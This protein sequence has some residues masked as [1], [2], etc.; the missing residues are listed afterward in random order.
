METKNQLLSWLRVPIGG[1]MPDGY[2]ISNAY[3]RNSRIANPTERSA[4]RTLCSCLVALLILFAVQGV[5]AGNGY[6]PTINT[7]SDSNVSITENG[8]N[9]AFNIV[10]WD[11]N[12]NN[13]YWDENACIKVNGETLCTFKDLLKGYF[14]IGKPYND[15]KGSYTEVAHDTAFYKKYTG[16]LIVTRQYTVGNTVVY[17]SASN[18]RKRA[19][20]DYSMELTIDI[21]FER[22]WVDFKRTIKWEGRWHYR[23]HK[24]YHDYD[25]VLYNCNAPSVSMPSITKDNFTRTGNKKVKFTYPSYTSYSGWTTQTIMYKADC[26]NS[27]LNPSTQ[28]YGTLSQTG[29]FNVSSNYDPVTIYPRFEYYKNANYWGSGSTGNYVFRFDKNYG[30]DGSIVIPGQPRPKNLTVTSTNTYNKHVTISWERDAY[31]SSTATN[32]NWIVIRRGSDGT[33]TNL[34]IG[35]NALSNDIY[36]YTD[37]SGNLNYGTTYTYVVCYKPNNWSVSSES[38]AEG[39][40]QTVNCTLNRDFAFSGETAKAENGKIT[41]SWSHNAIQDASATNKYD[42]V[43]QQSIDDGQTWS[44]VKTISIT[45]T[46]TTGG[47]YTLDNPNGY[48]PYYFRAKITVQDIV[49][50]SAVKSATS[51]QGS[52]LS[53]FTAS[54]GTYNTLVKVAWSVN[55]KGTNTTF[56]TLQR[57]PMGNTSESS[58]ATIYSTSGTANN[59]SY[60]DETAQPGSFNE[61]R[62]KIFDT[63]NGKLYEGTPL[64]TDGFCLAQGVM[65]GRITYGSGTAVEGARVTLN[66]TNADGQAIKS[67]RSLYFDGSVNAST[68]GSGLTCETDATDINNLFGKDFTI[69]MWLKPDAT[70]MTVNDTDYELFDLPSTFGLFIR[71][72]STGYWLRYMVSNNSDMFNKSIDT[73]KWTHLTVTYSQSAKKLTLYTTQDCINIKDKVEKTS[74]TISA[75]KLKA[76]TSFGFGNWSNLGCSTPYAGYMDEVRIFNRCLS[77]AEILKNCNHTLNGSEEGLQAYYPFDEG[78]AKQIKA[79]DFSRQN[80]VSNEHHMRAGTAARCEQNIVPSEEQLSLMTYTDTNGNYTVRGIPFSGDGTNY[81]ITPSLGIHKFA[82]SNQSRFVSINSLNFSTIDFEDTSSFPVSGTVYY[83]GT[84][85][86]VDSVQFFVDGAICARDG[87]P[88]MTGVDGKYT[89]DVPIG[90]HYIT[91]SRLHHTFADGGRYPADKNNTGLRETF[92]NKMEGIDFYDNTMTVLA[93]R[94]V[95]GAIESNKQLGFGLSKNNI[96]QARITLQTTD[97][98]YHINVTTTKVGTTTN[99]NYA[100]DTLALKSPTEKVHSRAWR[101]ATSAGDATAARQIVIETDPATGE[102]AVLLPPLRYEVVNVEFV[103]TNPDVHFDYSSTKDEVNVSRLGLETTDTLTTDKR[104]TFTYL[105]R[106]DKIYNAPIDFKVTQEGCPDGAFGLESVTYKD[107]VLEEHTVGNLYTIGANGNVSYAY[108][109]PIFQQG[110]QY[111]FN[112]HACQTYKNYDGGTTN[113]VVDTVPMDSMEVTASNGLSDEQYVAIRD[114][115]SYNGK[116]YKAGDLVEMQTSTF[117]LDAQGKATYAWTAG[118][119]DLTSPYN[120]KGFYF[121]YNNGEQWPA[122]K[123]A[124][125]GIILGCVPTG[126]NFTTAAPDVVEMVLRDPPGTNS[127]ATWEAGTTVTTTHTDFAKTVTDDKLI[128][129]VQAGFW[130]ETEAGV[131]VVV[132]TRI[133]AKADADAG[134]HSQTE[135]GDEHT[136]ITTTTLDR[137]ISTSDK[138][139]FVGAQGDVFIGRAKNYLFGAARTIG[140]KEE[141]TDN[142]VLDLD[143]GITRGVEYGTYFNYAQ[144]YIE[145]TLLPNLEG[146]RD[147]LLIYH[148]NPQSVAPVPGKII[149]VTN[150]KPGDYGY[151]SSNDDEKVWGKRAARYD[152]QTGPSYTMIIPRDAQGNATVEGVDSIKLYNNNIKGWH[153]TL[154]ANE[155]AKV[156]AKSN[157]NTYLDQNISFDSGSIITQ[158]MTQTYAEGTTTTEEF[159][160]T[161]ILNAS[162]GAL[163]CETGLIVNTENEWGKHKG[164]SDGTENENHSTVSYS[165]VEDG[166]DDA[167]SVDVFKSVD[168]FSPIFITRAGQTCCPYEGARYTKYYKPGYKLD[169]ATMQIEQPHILIDN[170]KNAVKSGVANGST[171]RFDVLLTN[172]SEIGEDVFFDVFVPSTGNANAANVGLNGEPVSV[173]KVSLLVPAGEAVKAVL[174][175]DQIDPSIQDYDSIAVVIASQCQQDPASTWEVIADTAYVS[176]HYVATSSPVTMQIASTTVNTSNTDETAVIKVGGYDLGFN[177]FKGVKLQYKYANDAAWTTFK[178]YHASD[179]YATPTSEQLPEGG[180]TYYYDMK[181]KS[182]GRYTFRAMS[183]ST[184]KSEDYNVFSDEIVVIKDMQ[185]PQLLGLANPSDG[186][187]S[188]GEEISVNFNEDIRSGAI[189]EL[190]SFEVIGELNEAQIDHNVGLKMEGSDRTAYTQAD[191]TLAGRS[192]SVESW[193]N[194]AGNGTL[195]AHGRGSNTFALGADNDGHLVAT[196]GRHTYTSVKTM[197]LNKWAYLMVS[198]NYEEGDSKLSAN[199]ATDDQTIGLF[200][201]ESV[202]DYTGNGNI[203]LGRQMTGAVQELTLWDSAHTL[204]EALEYMHITKKPTEP[205]LIGYWKFDEGNGTVANDVARNRNMT[206]TSAN[207]YL[208]NKNKA[209]TLDGSNAL[210]MDITA[211]S[212]GDND[213][214]AFEMWFKGSDTNKGATLFATSVTDGPKMAFDADGMLTLSSKGSTTQLSKKNYLDN[215][216]HHVALNVLRGGTASIYVDGTIAKQVSAKAVAALQGYALFIGANKQDD[217]FENYFTGSIDEVRLWHATLNGKTIQ[218]RIHNRLQGNENGLVAYYPFEAKTLDSGNQVIVVNSPLDNALDANGRPSTVNMASTAA[219]IAYSDEAPALKPAKNATNLDFSYVASERKIV[220]TLNNTP[221]MLEGTTVQFTVKNVAD[222]NG[223]YCL[224]I[225]WTAYIR[226]NQLLW[227]TDNASVKGEQGSDM[228]FTAQ[229]EN[230]SGQ[231]ATW[232]L[233]G[234]PS[235]LTASEMAGT[236]AAT[237]QKTLTFTVDPS[238]AIGKYES[239]I[240]LYGDNQIYEPFTVSLNVT[241]ETPN[242]V[243]TLGQSTMTVVGVLNINGQM[244]E[245]TEDMV[246]AFRGTECVGVAQPKYFSSYDSYMVMLNIYGENKADLTYKAYDAST[247]TIY[248][249]VEV[250]NAN[251]N[252]FVADKTVGSFDNPVTFTPLNE[253]EQDLSLNRAGWKWFSLYAM[254]KD[255]DPEVVFKDALDAISIVTDGN[256]VSINWIGLLELDNPA[257][258]YKLKTEMP[259]VETIVGT[260]TNCTDIDITLNSGWS[261]IGYPCQASNSLGAAFAAANPQEGDQVK[262]QTSFSIYTNNEWIGTLTAMVPGEGYLY[263]STASAAKTFKYPKPEV[264][265]KKNA[266]AHKT[267]ESHEPYEA[268]ESFEDNMTMIA[269]VMNGDELVENAEVSVYAGTELRGQSTEVVKD[270]KHFLTIGGKS[271][272]DDVLTFVVT[273]GESTYYLNQTELFH[274]NAMMGSMA[275][276]YVLQLGGTTGVNAIEYA[277]VDNYYDLQGRKVENAH[278]RKGVYINQ[279]KKVVVKK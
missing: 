250:S 160:T 272:E 111:T 52:T 134:V 139:E 51:S 271:G 123:T 24:N 142:Y 208:N 133:E 240:Y 80:G 226:Q 78:M 217:T 179:T 149:F 70:K 64:E 98:R 91:A 270:G 152:A 228:S 43:V 119:P 215:A 206:L 166:D 45:S 175:V 18:P 11:Y 75:D 68:G 199:I 48:Q 243:A 69:Q 248:P 127:S 162:V 124:Q 156:R 95:G 74:I 65:S 257:T 279:S 168:A 15:S 21:A 106:F 255:S 247:G 234:L 260:P 219:D 237:K 73:D 77:Q 192:F 163:F 205:G 72:S 262:N 212:S 14:T 223:N 79:Y 115:A 145:N 180:L 220:F 13:Y 109:A 55:Q 209:V 37:M 213:D 112:I 99:R 263:N 239:T 216:W 264:S 8:L 241:G 253:I 200:G 221:D 254:P 28:A 107:A 204:A 121:T 266:P 196:I 186:I 5:R 36:S 81:I 16:K 159:T 198:Y 155:E 141:S 93:G 202:A 249:S 193:V 244:S 265:G 132:V 102:Y 94:V 269:V 86:P 184:F 201:G 144:N 22:Y 176:V 17:V 164:N 259:Y 105:S 171:A 101:N 129:H 88:V 33:Q 49:V 245:D 19:N 203:T 116:T 236:V 227:L 32:G 61:Y 53:S 38:D 10:Y 118:F 4:G 25:V 194:I 31:D 56:F 128:T 103:K 224:P 181:G 197:P 59:Y 120:H 7:T 97:E 85:I 211:I 130:Q 169:E 158:S 6:N 267:H 225:V 238:T 229:F 165:L 273:T 246:A 277:P 89:I 96:G 143:M 157:R 110:E 62:L 214:Y 147:G 92:M 195:F 256:A 60:D 178:E 207:W 131:G 232:A 173:K 191:I 108:N 174:T 44:D 29:E 27:W 261:W 104:Q 90:D 140:F 47:S 182:D 274:A 235:W 137:A 82:P 76:A 54:R 26:T 151:G 57:R 126:V 71:K 258:M 12:E 183:T 188:A 177:G 114:N 41:F 66:T 190:T 63:N 210:Q 67:N 251:A 9:Y 150:L 122:P 50:Y 242:W 275:Q 35:N 39:L 167:I 135:R 84:D 222:M 3:T 154:A 146:L 100:K 230:T 218:S 153:T 83:E 2:G 34:A 87:V 30:K 170:V 23:D 148:E 138:P 58:W 276:P 161:A 20:T 113:P 268:Y 231:N 187:L 117:H 233:S 172:T 278:M 189:N 125:Q 136:V 185:R 46:S 252:E 40:S 42:L 1:L